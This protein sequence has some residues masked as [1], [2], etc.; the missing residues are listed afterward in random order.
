MLGP[1]VAAQFDLE[2]A[3]AELTRIGASTGIAQSQLLKL[4]VLQREISKADGPALVAIYANVAGLIAVTQ[5][6]VQ[7]G[8]DAAGRAEV[9]ETTLAAVNARTRETVQRI[10]GDLF[11]RRIF[12]PYLQFAS[13]EEEEAY[14]K[15][16]AGRQEYINR[17]L[18][19]GT[20]HGNL[21]ASNAVLAQIDD[22][23]SH[24]ADQS[25][26]FDKLRGEAVDTIKAQRDAM[27]GAGILS[28]Q[29]RT[30]ETNAPA[31]APPLL[32]P[33]EL[34]EVAAA[35][36]AAGVQVPDAPSTPAYAHGLGD[37]ASLQPT[38]PYRS[39]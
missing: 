16:E 19:K 38:I 11:E 13:P 20:P 14:R 9:N 39:V 31:T 26:D 15:R 10:A 18:S 36:R 28:V 29:D 37:T 30:A 17:E 35:L 33:S 21:N 3:I 1:L 23:G 6:I 24:G 32:S 12:D 7:Q 27:Q 2:N 5:A 8:R 25:P 4:S 34:D 22:A